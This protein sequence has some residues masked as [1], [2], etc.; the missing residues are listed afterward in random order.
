MEDA[1]FALIGM[2]TLCGT[3]RNVIDKLRKA[4]KK[5]GLIRLRS[6]RPFPKARLLKACKNLK[7]LAVID[8]HVSYGFEGPLFTDV[9]SAFFDEKNR[10]F[11]SGFIAGLG[12]RDITEQHLEKA[13]L[14]ALQKKEGEWLF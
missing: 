6:L 3:A 1:E 8:R 9:R 2:G 10:P 7:A 13:L 5:A 12:G 14:G 11:V 4:G